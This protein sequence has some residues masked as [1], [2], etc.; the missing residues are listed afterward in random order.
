[1][2]GAGTEDGFMF[3][4]GAG[5]YSACLALFSALSWEMLA[6]RDPCDTELFKEELGRFYLWG[7]GFR[8]SKLDVLLGAF[9][10]LGDSILRH[11][12]SIG[13]LLRDN[14]DFSKDLSYGL[15]NAVGALE[16]TIES[17]ERIVPSQRDLDALPP[18]KDDGASDTSSSSRS[19][20]FELL[21]DLHFYI[22]LLM[23]LIPSMDRSLAQVAK[24]KE[25]QQVD[26]PLDSLRVSSW[27]SRTSVATSSKSPSSRVKL[28]SDLSAGSSIE[29]RLDDRRDATTADASSKTDLDL[30]AATMTEQFRHTLSLKSLEAPSAD[31][32]TKYMPPGP[33]P[34]PYTVMSNS[35]LVPTMPS[36]E[37]DLKFRN[38]LLTLSEYPLKYENPGL[39]DEALLVVPVERIHSEAEEEY[40]VLKAIAASYSDEAKSEWGYQDC[41]V[42]SLLR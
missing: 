5:L 23:S 14:T 16:S 20:A 2:S 32:L 41:V 40:Q 10:G 36:S 30:D 31:K 1:M 25:Q 12:I 37:R 24:D 39:L 9:P 15:R 19:T 4:T 17:A 6:L 21:D 33:K 7:E 26:A 3:G 35:P 38:L 11:L 13:T 27:S 22:G 29:S 34:P 18:A 42:V 8:G 28:R